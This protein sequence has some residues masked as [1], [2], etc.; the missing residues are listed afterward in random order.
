MLLEF[1]ISCTIPSIELDSVF[2]MGFSFLYIYDF[3]VHMEPNLNLIP[4]IPSGIA[5]IPNC[6][7]GMDLRNLKFSLKFVQLLECVFLTFIHS[8]WQWRK[9]TFA[10]MEKLILFKASARNSK[11]LFVF[12]FF[13][14]W[15]KSESWGHRTAKTRW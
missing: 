13:F 8:K 10:M 14:V 12:F 9:F 3:N 7:E 4:A 5:S 6:S 15:Q 2:F 11:E 1:L